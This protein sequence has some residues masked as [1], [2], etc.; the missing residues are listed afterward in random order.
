[1]V[2]TWWYGHG[3]LKLGPRELGRHLGCVAFFLVHGELGQRA[4][5]DLA[6]SA[7]ARN[8]ATVEDDGVE[9]RRVEAAQCRAGGRL[10]QHSRRT[11]EVHHAVC[12]LVHLHDLQTGEVA[13]YLYGPIS[14]LWDLL[15][16][17]QR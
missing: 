11:V 2:G 9:R 6:G 10:P 1:M 8:D 4:D 5:R 7:V 15:K 17:K 13:D 14:L 16:K 12:F 3:G